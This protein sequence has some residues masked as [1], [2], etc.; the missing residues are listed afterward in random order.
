MSVTIVTIA[1]AIL[2]VAAAAGT[3]VVTLRDGYR[4]QPTR[5]NR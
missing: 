4:Q 5:F 1:L 2:G 3:L